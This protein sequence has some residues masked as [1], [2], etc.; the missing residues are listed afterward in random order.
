MIHCSY[1]KKN[2]SLKIKQPQKTKFEV[3]RNVGP[4]GNLELSPSISLLKHV[5]VIFLKLVVPL[6]LFLV[7]FLFIFHDQIF[8][9][10]YEWKNIVSLPNVA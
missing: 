3:K 6:F 5:A 8:F 4:S 9:L 7:T 10:N 1:S 2:D